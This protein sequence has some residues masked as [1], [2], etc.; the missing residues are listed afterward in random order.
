MGAVGAPPSGYRS[1]ADTE[2]LMAR[3][4]QGL[5]VGNHKRVRSECNAWQGPGHVK[6]QCLS[7]K[8]EEQSFLPGLSVNVE[9]VCRKL[10]LFP[11][12][13]LTAWRLL[14]TEIAPTKLS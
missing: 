1:T 4:F 8:G 6:D 2:R 13:L 3:G 9:S 14:L 5:G 7:S 11:T 12:P 10:E